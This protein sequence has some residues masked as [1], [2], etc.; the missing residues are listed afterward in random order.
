MEKRFVDSFR[1]SMCKYCTRRIFVTHNSRT[2]LIVDDGKEGSYTLISG[3][4]LRFPGSGVRDAIREFA[5]DI[6]PGT[7]RY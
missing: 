3:S 7:P 1:Q 6:I 2:P 5:Q 4:G